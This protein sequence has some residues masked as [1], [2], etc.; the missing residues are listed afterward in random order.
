[1]KTPEKNQPDWFDAALAATQ[2]NYQRIDVSKHVCGHCGVPLHV[3]TEPVRREKR[4]P[5]SSMVE[6]TIYPGVYAFCGCAQSLGDRE[7]RSWEEQA[8][9]YH[10]KIAAPDSDEHMDNMLRGAPTT[11]FLRLMRE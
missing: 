7:G 11:E 4:V 1:M 5:G 6:V 2:N 8:A 9:I 3:A 10:A